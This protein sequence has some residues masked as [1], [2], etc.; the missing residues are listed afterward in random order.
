MEVH[1]IKVGL[2]AL[3]QLLSLRIFSFPISNMN[4]MVFSSYRSITEVS[5]NYSGS[6][7]STQTKF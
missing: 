6:T 5:T 2:V 4:T 1:E 7:L 3:G